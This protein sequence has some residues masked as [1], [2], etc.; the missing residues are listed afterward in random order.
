M[1]GIYAGDCV[2]TAL[3]NVLRGHAVPAG[4]LSLY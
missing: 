3:R 2:S 4:A 1:T